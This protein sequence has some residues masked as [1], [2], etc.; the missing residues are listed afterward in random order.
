MIGVHLNSGEIYFMVTYIDSALTKPVVISLEFVEDDGDPESP[1]V[2]KLHEPFSSSEQPTLLAY[3]TD[4]VS[5]LI[6]I[7]ETISELSRAQ[8]RLRLSE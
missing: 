6:S 7:E 2:F 3:T 4:Q 1:Y 8:N 5:E